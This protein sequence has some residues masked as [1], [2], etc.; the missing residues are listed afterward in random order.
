MLPTSAIDRQPLFTFTTAIMCLSST[1]TITENRT[2]HVHLILVRMGHGSQK[3]I[4]RQR[5][6]HVNDL[7]ELGVNFRWGI[8]AAMYQQPAVFAL[9]LAFKNA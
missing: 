5:Y 8:A 7:N 6:M 2:T 9:Q 1:F 4:F 3:L